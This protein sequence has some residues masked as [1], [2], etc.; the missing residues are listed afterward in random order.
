MPDIGA[1]QRQIDAADDVAIF[2]ERNL[3]QQQRLAAG[4][5]QQLENVSNAACRAV[6]LVQE[7]NARNAQVVEFAHDELEGRNLLSSASATTTA[8][9]AAA[10]TGSDSNA[11][12]I[13]PGQS[14]NVMLSPMN[15]VV[16]IVAF[17]LMACAFA[18][19]E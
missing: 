11:N 13:E 18:S 19:A 15:S 6:D 17:T 16:A 3:A 14:M 1:L 12:S 4:R 2:A 9:S 8:T 5:L 7:E 10:S